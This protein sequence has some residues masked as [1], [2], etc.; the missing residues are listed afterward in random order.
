MIAENPMAD[1]SLYILHTRNPRFIAEVKEQE[2][3]PMVWLDEQDLK[4]ERLTG[5]MQRMNDWYV[6][7]TNWKDG[8][9]SQ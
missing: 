9:F 2:I 1:S 7:Y 3:T 8:N 4:P 6:A 5:L